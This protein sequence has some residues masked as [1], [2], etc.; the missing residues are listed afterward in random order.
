VEIAG[1]VFHEHLVLR[2]QHYGDL[3]LVR[4]GAQDLQQGAEQGLSLHL[5]GGQERAET[6]THTSTLDNPLKRALSQTGN[7]N[8]KGNALGKRSD[9]AGLPGKKEILQDESLD[10]GQEAT[11][12]VPGRTEAVGQLLLRSAKHKGRLQPFGSHGNGGGT[13]NQVAQILNENTK[14]AGS[15]RVLR[16]DDF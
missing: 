6:E 5:G 13:E 11:G 3:A 12:G 16:A 9:A 10:D 8:G 15:S 7:G 4:D 1:T 14:C 2:R